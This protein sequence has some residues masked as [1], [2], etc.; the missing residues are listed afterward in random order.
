MSESYPTGS[1]LNVTASSLGGSL[2]QVLLSQD[3]QPG[4]PPSYE[5]CKLIYL[6]H[7][8]GL[9]L[10]EAPIKLA[11]SVDRSIS[12]QNAPEEVAKAFETEWNKIK[13]N[14]NILNVKSLS[15]VY[16]IAAIVMGIEGKESS[17]P[18]DLSKL[19]EEDIYFNVLDP[20]NTAG[21]LVITQD[22]T[23]PDFNKPTDVSVGGEVYHKSRAVIVMNENPIYLAY[24]SS[25]FGYVG[26][27]VYQRSL[28]PLKSFIRTMRTDEMIARKAGLLVAKTVTPG[29]IVDQLMQTAMGIKRSVLKQGETDEVISI[30]TEEDIETLNMMNVDGAGK[31]ARD[32]ILNNIATAAGM[33]AVIIRNESYVQGFSEGSE[34]AKDVVRFVDEFRIEMTPI[35]AFFDT[36]TQY[37]AWNPNFYKIIQKKYPQ[38]YGDKSFEEAFS[39]WRDDFVTSWPSLMIEP[40]SEQVNVEKTKLDGIKDFLTAILPSLDPKNVA[41]AIQW[42]ADN[43]SENKIM[44]PHE[45]VLDINA[46]A[47]F[48]EEQ[49]E[50]QA[51]MGQMGQP[52]GPGPAPGGAQ[53]LG[54]PVD[55]Q[56]ANAAPP[57]GKPKPKAGNKPDVTAEKKNGKK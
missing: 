4:S 44:F 3:I 34:D 21:S 49:V 23:A 7:P 19:W 16:G 2:Q 33:P 24:T 26:R 18:F 51:Q 56:K 35:Y 15:R 11:Q 46:L 48:H 47:D 5:L 10:A 6:Y 57:A 25:A 22:S 17:A 40:E 20:L 8:L 28:Y 12:I 42:A 37:R 41:I 36:I 50:Q 54:D 38:Q 13:A 29:S 45:L 53:K 30:D 9:K 52:E 55:Q 27:S 31:F 43:I 32:N 14:N 1:N 39:E